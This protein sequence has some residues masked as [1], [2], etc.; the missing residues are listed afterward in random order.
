ML[1]ILSK[2]QIGLPCSWNIER[3]TVAVNR[4]GGEEKKKERERKKVGVNI[5]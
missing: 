1:R 2:A 4:R 3:E 5:A